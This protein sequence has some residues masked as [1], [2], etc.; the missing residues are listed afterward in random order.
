M[1]SAHRTLWASSEINS[2]IRHK[3]SLR[4]EREEEQ[5]SP[6]ETPHFNGAGFVIS[7]QHNIVVPHATVEKWRE[8]Y[9]HLPDFD[10][11]LEKLAA[12]ILDKG[13]KHAGWRSPTTWIPDKLAEDNQKAQQRV[14]AGGGSKR[15]YTR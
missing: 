7:R 8:R 15:T 10:T 9:T 3:G 14:K 13:P 5:G 12:I 4:E 2:K 11:K 1:G 6:Y